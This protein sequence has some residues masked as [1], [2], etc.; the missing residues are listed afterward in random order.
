MTR[1]LQTSA[2]R[3][4]LLTALSSLCIV[5]FASD[6]KALPAFPGAEGF[7]SQTPGGRGGKVIAVT[8][9]NDSGPGSFRAACETE[10]PRIIVFRVTGI[11]DLKSPIRITKPY[12][13]IAGQSAPGEGICLR[14]FNIDV[15]T[16][17]VIMRYLRSRP[18]DIEGKE[19][20]AI[21]V[22]SG[23]SNV[24]I[25]HCS[26]SWSVDEGLSP[27]GSI[28]NVTVQ[29][30]I[31]AEGL[32]RSV[33]HKGSHGFGSLVRAIG[34]VSLH[35]NLW[36]HNN[37]RNPRLGDNYQRPP[38][39]TFDVRNNV[40]YNYGD[41]CS[42]MTGDNLNANYVANYIRPGTNSN[43]SRGVIVF[44]DTADARYY[45]ADNFVEGK[46]D[47]NEDNGKLFDRTEI[48]GKKV[49]T[50]TDKP[51]ATPEIKTTSAEIAFKE[52]LKDV[53]ATRPKRDSVDER[54]VRSVQERTGTIIDS[55]K[56]V[57]GWP[58]YKTAPAP[59]D[60][61]G[62]GMPD[63]WEKEHHL[64]PADPSDANVDSDGDGYTNVEEYLNATNPQ[65]RE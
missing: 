57:G 41:I 51:F 31:I 25:D 61:D 16:T 18:G 32:N 6:V 15:R 33:H 21:D 2:V 3:T 52:V 19:V 40:I 26:A 49:V 58:E 27:S 24:I 14:G 46:A 48:K 34:G 29:W 35:H 39:P 60:S 1:T 36:A 62:D 28:S 13:T 10:G 45:V 55:E 47:M 9:L 54:I 50:R 65:K 64:N 8:N 11:I 5:T 59:E 4:L 23:S 56:Q 12:V 7:G 63:Q 44:T 37:G 42:G 17:D 53:G 22:S 20:D 43:R 38:Y 30:C